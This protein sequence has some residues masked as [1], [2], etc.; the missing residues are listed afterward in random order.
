MWGEEGQGEEE[1][2]PPAASCPAGLTQNCS[3]DIP[4]HQ[5]GGAVCFSCKR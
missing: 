3:Q 1:R 5:L 4:S 2:S